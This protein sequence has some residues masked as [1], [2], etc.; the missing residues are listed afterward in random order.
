MKITG[1]SGILVAVAVGGFSG[2]AAAAETTSVTRTKSEPT[3]VFAQVG[4]GMVE[5]G[6]AEVGAFLGPHLT[7][8]AMAAWSGVFGAHYGGAVMYSVGQAQGRRPPRHAL[9]VGARLMLDPTVT[10][11]SR[12]DDLNSYGVIPVGYGYLSDSGFYLRATAGLVVFGERNGAEGRGL[13][14]SGPLFNFSVGFAF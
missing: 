9:L 4:T 13:V 12:G 2:R 8:E 11:E 6:H 7:I 1:V 3:H 14:V 5:L 10:F